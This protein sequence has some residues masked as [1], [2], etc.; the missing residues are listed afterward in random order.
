MNDDDSR[1]RGVLT[2][3][4]RAFLRGEATLRSEQSAYDARYRIRRRLRNAVLDLALLFERMESRDR[5]RVFADDDLDDALVD[6]LALLYR[7][8]GDGDR[9]RRATFVEAVHRA[10]RQCGATAVSATFEVE[11]TTASVDET[12]EKIAQGAY[13]D[14]TEAELRAFAHHCGEREDV[15]VDDLR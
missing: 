2:P 3:A 12:V 10:E 4:D 9:S 8:V 5:E 14:L 13:R 1:D 7:G 11:R 6:A 15:D